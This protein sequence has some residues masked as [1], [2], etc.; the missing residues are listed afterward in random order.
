MSNSYRQLPIA[1]LQLPIAA[2]VYNMWEA[3]GSCR[4]L[5]GSYKQLLESCLNNLVLSKKLLRWNASDVPAP[6][7]FCT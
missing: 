2:E 3:I 1:A 6:A 5:L 4:Q 7:L